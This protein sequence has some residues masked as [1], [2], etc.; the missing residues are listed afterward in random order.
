MSPRDACPYTDAALARHLD[1]DLDASG[2]L[3]AAF[4]L[5]EHLRDCPQ[6]R[7][8][9]RMSRRLDAVLAEASGRSTHEFASS[10]RLSRVLARATAAATPPPPPAAPPERL[11]FL[12]RLLMATAMVGFAFVLAEAGLQQ[13]RL[14]RTP[15]PTGQ[16]ARAAVHPLQ[17]ADD[18]AAPTTPTGPVTPFPR[19]LAPIPATSLPLP[20]FP[21]HRAPGSALAMAARNDGPLA[22]HH[23]TAMVADRQLAGHLQFAATSLRLG[24]GPAASLQ[25]QALAAAM[26]W[27][28]GI[29]LLDADRRDLVLA[30][31]QVL[32]RLDDGSLLAGLAA[33]IRPRPAVLQLLRRTLDGEC[34]RNLHRND[35]AALELFTA[36]ARIGGRELDDTLR[37]LVRRQPDLAEPLAAALRTMRERQGRGRLL[38][39]VFADL[40]ARS[41]GTDDDRTARLLFAGQPVV[42]ELQDEFASCREAPRRRRI[43]LALGVRGDPSALPLL[44]QAVR[45]SSQT[46]AIA[47]A[48]AIGQMPVDALEQLVARA[49]TP[50]QWLLRAALALAG[51]PAATNWL[52]GLDLTRAERA[53]LLLGGLDFP[54]FALSAPLFRLRNLSGQ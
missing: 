25:I 4:D 40:V 29:Q 48:W 28:A 35:L 53:T 44:E 23:L 39:D 38:L 52:A 47:A 36:A 49:Q 30:G 17:P 2:D 27:R 31:C 3:L 7:R 45:S 46:E 16:L 32:G 9:L 34:R 42:G 12:A 18:A 43:L 6:C 5:A 26:R 37:T 10:Q 11:P 24:T 50:D 13:P 22:A 1:G 54:A 15:A 41:A 20:P 8:E 21:A 33:E 51:V 19:R 14:P